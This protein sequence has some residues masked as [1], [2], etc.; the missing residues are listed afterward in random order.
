MP[1]PSRFELW[2]FT[3]PTP[4]RRGRFPTRRLAHR[5]ALRL[6]LTAYQVRPVPAPKV[7]GR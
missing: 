3:P 2:D 7:G 6:G 1:P 4:F 5:M